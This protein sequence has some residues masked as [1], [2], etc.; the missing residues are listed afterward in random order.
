M[1]RP[2]LPVPDIFIL[3]R[4]PKPKCNCGEC[5]ICRSRA[6]RQGYW[7]RRK[8]GV[9]VEPYNALKKISQQIGKPMV[10]RKPSFT[11]FQCDACTLEYLLAEG[12]DFSACQRY[13]AFLE[14]LAAENLPV[15]R[16]L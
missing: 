1:P 10:I 14:G 5:G 15:V 2:P 7:R 3:P 13:R 6:Y 8:A 4:G 12:H 16:E 11:W 9:P